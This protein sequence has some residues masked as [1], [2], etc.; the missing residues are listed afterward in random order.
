MSLKSKP[1]VFRLAMSPERV[2]NALKEYWKSK[3]TVKKDTIVLVRNTSGNEAS[4]TGYGDTM[5][6]YSNEGKADL[7]YRGEMSNQSAVIA[8]PDHRRSAFH[9]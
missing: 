9:H 8:R 1:F 3:Q 5:V 4:L 6:D 7:E 2:M